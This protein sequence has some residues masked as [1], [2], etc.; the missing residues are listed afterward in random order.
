[1]LNVLKT[2]LLGNHCYDPHKMEVELQFLY[3]IHF[4]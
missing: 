3:Y 1:M 4:D 2:L